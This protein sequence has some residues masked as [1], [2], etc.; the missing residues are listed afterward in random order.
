MTFGVDDLIASAAPRTKPVRVCARGDLVDRHAAL[1]AEMAAVTE[2]GTGSIAGNPEVEAIAARIVAVEEEQEASTLTIVLR[3]VSRRA[4]ADTLAK[5]P[6]RPQDKGLDH[7]PVSFPPAAVALCAAEP[8][9][10]VDQAT[11]LADTLPPGEWL[12]LWNAALALNLAETPHPKLAVAS[13]IA[14]PSG[15]S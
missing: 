13:E 8:E 10:S 2:A 3:S 1:V 11:K 4:W 9:I 7:N 14:R 5:N 6:P 15:A 12:K